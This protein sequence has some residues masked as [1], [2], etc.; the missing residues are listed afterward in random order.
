MFLY[1]LYICD[2]QQTKP[3]SIDNGGGEFEDSMKFAKQVKRALN[4]VKSS[5]VS[6]IYG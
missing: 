4:K 3:Q 6:S 2:R 5:Y 1:I